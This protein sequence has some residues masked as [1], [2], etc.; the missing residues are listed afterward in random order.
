MIKFKYDLKI[1]RTI[2][3]IE[4]E[5][6]SQKELFEK[7]SPMQAVEIAANGKDDVYLSVRTTK[8]GDKYY[9]LVCPSQKLEYPFGVLKDGDGVLFPGKYNKTEKKTT[10]GWIT[11]QHGT[12]TD[13]EEGTESEGD[14]S[15]QSKVPASASANHDNIR[16]LANRPLSPEEKEKRALALVASKAIT[17]T[18]GGYKVQVN[19]AVF[20]MIKRVDGKVIC[21]CE[22]FDPEAGCEHRLA[23]SKFCNEVHLRQREELKL[24]IADLIEAG[25]SDDAID[26]MIARVCDGVCAVDQ[27]DASQ[28]AKAIRTLAGKLED[29]RIS[30]AVNQ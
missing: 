26:Q 18:D 10:Q 22:Q 30:K 8:G 17:Q 21:N 12:V 7:I 19:S 28:V 1:G 27:L 5:A 23:V 24:L 4:D 15:L 2:I 6:A 9:A 25:F 20:Y 16:H 3:H 14:P 29:A 11:L 13:S